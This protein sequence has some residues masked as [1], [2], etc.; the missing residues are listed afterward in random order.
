VVIT[1][2]TTTTA[3]VVETRTYYETVVERPARRSYS[4]PVYRRPAPTKTVRRA[5]PRPGE[6]G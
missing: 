6:R 1:E 2:T 5:A 3:P 4:K